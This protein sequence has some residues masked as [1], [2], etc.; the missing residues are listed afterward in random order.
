VA[1]IECRDMQT[2]YE[3]TDI[4]PVYTYW[5]FAQKMSAL[6]LGQCQM[7]LK[8]HIDSLTDSHIQSSSNKQTATKTQIESKLDSTA[9][10]NDIAS[11]HRLKRGMALRTFCFVFTKHH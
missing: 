1:T 5:S 11:R 10:Y 9:Y 3:E 2:M 4:T 8:K 6:G 7:I